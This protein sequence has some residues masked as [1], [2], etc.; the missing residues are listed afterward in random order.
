MDEEIKA[1]LEQAEQNYRN[2]LS[3]F[4]EVGK[5]LDEIRSKNGRG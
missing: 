4:Y 2:A 1:L 3:A 5:N